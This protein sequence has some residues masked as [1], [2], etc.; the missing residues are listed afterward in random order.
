V[1][2]HRDEPPRVNLWR[3]DALHHYFDMKRDPSR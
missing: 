3:A 1:S 2:D